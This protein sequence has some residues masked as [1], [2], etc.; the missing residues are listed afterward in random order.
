MKQVSRFRPSNVNAASLSSLIMLAISGAS[1]LSTNWPVDANYLGGSLQPTSVQQI[2]LAAPNDWSRPQRE[3]ASSSWIPIVR[4]HSINASAPLKSSESQTPGSSGALGGARNCS[5]FREC[6]R[7]TSGVPAGSQKSFE[8]STKPVARVNQ[9]VEGEHL[10]G[11][12]ELDKSSKTNG[13]P[14]SKDTFLGSDSVS[15]RSS[16]PPPPPLVGAYGESELDEDDREAEDAISSAPSN[17][18]PGPGGEQS[19]EEGEGGREPSSGAESA[20]QDDEAA[21]RKEM[22]AAEASEAEAENRAALDEQRQAQ[23]EIILAQAQSEAKAIKEQQEALLRQQ[24][25]QQQILMRRHQSDLNHH[26]DVRGQ[27]RRVASEK[28]ASKNGRQQ[29][30]KLVKEGRPAVEDQNELSNGSGFS[31]HHHQQ[32]QQQINPRFRQSARSA[33]MTWPS[34]NGYE[35]YENDKRQRASQRRRGNEFY[36][37]AVGEHQQTLPF[38]TMEHRRV[39]PEQF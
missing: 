22:E 10:G 32:Q 2:A 24:Q 35:P 1:L 30:R 15:M 11:D 18:G 7:V 29:R 25:L 12:D 38:K 34:A 3:P 39:R 6:N 19:T 33:Q 4:R 28:G 8:L 16:L 17:R 37:S 14:N 27:R 23:R 36:G 26:D 21:A 13:R 31:D 20:Q 5:G 9:E